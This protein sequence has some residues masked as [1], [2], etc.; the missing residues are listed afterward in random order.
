MKLPKRSLPEFTTTLPVS[1]LKVT[2]RPYTIKEERIL[3]LATMSDNT[4]DKFN[5]LKQILE[6][7]C[8]VEIENLHP[9][10]V[11][12]LYLKLYSVSESPEIQFNYS[13][14]FNSC[15]I[16]DKTDEL[17]KSTCPKEIKGTLN[18]DTQVSVVGLDEMKKIGKKPRGDHNSRIIDLVDGIKLQLAY[19][20]LDVDITDNQIDV[21]SIIYEL[22]VAV[23]APNEEDSGVTDIIPKEEFSLEEFKEFYSSFRP[24]DLEQLRD[25]FMNNARCVADL[26]VKCTTCNKQFNVQQTG[27]LNFLV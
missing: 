4:S 25:Y 24:T 7:C 16:T 23:F 27:L 20:T 21:P 9:A 2:Y 19:K 26:S 10:D 3:D 5:A 13:V 17:Y 11:D 15:G 22:L 1:N 8:S 18:I 14:D 6:N 12:W